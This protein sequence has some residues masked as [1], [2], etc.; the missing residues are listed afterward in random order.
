M[1]MVD[2]YKIKQFIIKDVGINILVLSI[3]QGLSLL[4]GYNHRTY[5]VYSPIHSGGD[6]FLLFFLIIFLSILNLGANHIFCRLV[7]PG[8][9]RFSIF[10][11]SNDR[12]L[13][14]LL[15]AAHIL[16]WL[17]YFV[18]SYP[19][20]A[21]YDVG[22]QICQIMGA[23]VLTKANPLLQTL[24]S[25]GLFMFGTKIGRPEVGIAFYII[26]QML[27]SSLVLSYSIVSLCRISRSKWIII[28]MTISYAVIPV[29][30]LYI[31][32]IGKDT[33]FGIQ[34]V[35]ALT[36]IVN[37]YESNKLTKADRVLFPVSLIL[38]SL[39]RNAGIFL[40]I[41]FA[42]IAVIIAS[43][44]RKFSSVLGGGAIA[45]V[46]IFQ[47]VTTA[48]FHIDMKVNETENLSIP[49]LQMGG[50]LTEYYN[51]LNEEELYIIDKVMSI[52]TV[53][54]EYDVEISDSIKTAY[55][56]RNPSKNDLDEFYR[57]YRKLLCKHPLKFLEVIV[58]KSYGYFDPL[59]GYINKPFTIV[60]L[61]PISGY[62][63]QML[64]I[65]I[66]N[67]F[68]LTGLR[69]LVDKMVNTPGIRIITHCGFYMWLLLFDAFMAIRYRV[70]RLIFLPMSAFVIGLIASPV[71][72][73]F[74]Y[75]FPLVLC[76]PFLT[77]MVYGVLSKRRYAQN[78]ERYV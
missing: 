3:I 30:P 41:F 63:S 36:C 59:T 65:N 46:L 69:M 58:A 57:L 44:G 23:E 68:D 52:D 9:D 4:V 33:N 11:F 67:T 60:G 74:R 55:I 56:E 34:I 13:F 19:G 29:I 16:C 18:F 48:V 54:K 21:W 71:N 62:I 14:W 32:A 45:A 8:N 42:V 75:N 38:M 40:A 37:T 25:G 24:L 35:L 20:G 51:E 15:F 7:D 66:S 50:Y 43:E 12:R 76:T 49:L 10:L 53:K 6:F 39:F 61:D 73:Y 28:L 17:P 70:N 78:E 64:G 5:L 27:T 1:H 77:L 22:N 31:I 72:A 26:I 2:F 47:A